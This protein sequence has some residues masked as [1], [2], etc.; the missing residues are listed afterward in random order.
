MIVGFIVFV[1]M[2]VVALGGL[3]LWSLGAFDGCGCYEDDGGPYGLPTF[4]PCSAH[5][6]TP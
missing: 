6:S 4:H 1:S 3:V 2:N 5:R